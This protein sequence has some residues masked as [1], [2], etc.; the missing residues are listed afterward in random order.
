MKGINYKICFGFLSGL[1][2]L[3]LFP[4]KTLA[5]CPMCVVATGVLTGVFRWLG[6]DD[7]I[8]GLWL[9]SFTTSL[10]IALNNFLVRKQRKIKFQLFLVLLGLYLAFL[11]A[12]Y[13]GGAFASYNQTWGVN[14]ILFG[15]IIG[16]ILL[17]LS[18]H[19]DRFL[20]KQNQGKIFFSHQKVVIA[21]GLLL[22]ASLIFYFIT[23]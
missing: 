17:S 14:K 11:V 9:G 13:W 8:I 6:V 1:F 18:L 12:L 7:V 22:A 23:K 21:I 19:F 2:A 3:L 10:A 5:F 4:L 15:I 20:R 16:N